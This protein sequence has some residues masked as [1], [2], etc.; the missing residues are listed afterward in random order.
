MPQATMAGR[1]EHHGNEIRHQREMEVG[2]QCIV[3]R[4]LRCRGKV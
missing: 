1:G 4:A 3:V 2:M